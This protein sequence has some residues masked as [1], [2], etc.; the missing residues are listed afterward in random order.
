[1]PRLVWSALAVVLVLCAGVFAGVQLHR[2]GEGRALR[3]TAPGAEPDP[4]PPVVFALGDSYTAGVRG[5]RPENAYAAETAR[6]LG[7]QIVVAGRAMTGFANTIGTNETFASL[8]TTQLAWRPAPDMLLI[9]GGHNDVRMRPDTIT[10]R[11]NALLEGVRA[12]WPRTQVVVMGPMW[13]GDP[14]PRA[15]RVRDVLRGVAAARRVPFI[16]PLAGRWIT[17]DPRRGTGNAGSLILQ[18]GTHPNAAGSRHIAQRLAGDL[19][20]LKLDKPALGRTK[21][22]YTGPDT[23]PTISS[24]QQAI[25]SEP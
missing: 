4:R 25:P 15:L 16:D 24:T 22:G 8:F 12:R 14:G 19:R 17:G 10:Q 9:S 3:G 21:V 13:G 5:I 18:D 20:A 1:V 7:W 23:S 11:A 2:I 6:V